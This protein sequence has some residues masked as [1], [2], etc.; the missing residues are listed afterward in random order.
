MAAGFVVSL[1]LAALYLHIATR[2][3]EA[4][5]QIVVIQKDANL[6]AQAVERERAEESSSFNDL[7]ATHVQVFRSP[8]VLQRAV[9]K[10]QL[11]R[12]PTFVAESEKSELFDP[13]M[14]ITKNLKV[15]KGGDAAEKDARVLRASFRGPSR[16]DCVTVLDAVVESYQSFLGETF[17]GTSSEA[18]RL[19][20]QAEKDLEGELRKA[21]EDYRNFREQSSLL[22]RSEQRTANPY[23]ER[24]KDIDTALIQ[25]KLRQSEVLSRL[26]VVRTAMQS[27]GEKRPTDLEQLA[28]IGQEEMS[29]IALMIATMRGDA[30]TS[31]TFQSKQPQRLVVAEAE[32]R[33]L[34]SLMLR[35]R[36]MLVDYGS[37]HP[38]IQKI[39]DQIETGREFLDKKSPP[40]LQRK[41]DVSPGELFSAYVTLLENDLAQLERREKRLLELSTQETAAGKKLVSAEIRDEILRANI[42][43]KR[44]MYDA[45][46]DRMKKISLIKDYS[47][48]LTPVISPV[49]AAKK[50]VSPL[51]SLVLA[52]GGFLGIFAGAA[53]GYVIDLS[54]RTFRTPEEVCRLLELPILGD[55]PTI[56]GAKRAGA[57]NGLR[58]ID[59]KA[60]AYHR[61]QSPEA[62]MIR[63]LRTAFS[64][65]SRSHGQK[66]IQVTSPMSGDGKTLLVANLAVSLAHAGKKVLIV[67]ADLRK[68]MIAKFFSIDSGV[69]LSSVISG[70]VDLPDAVQD[71]G[72]E[73]LFV[74]PSG[75]CPPNPSEFL[76]SREFEQL[77]AVVRNQY[78]Y[79]LIDSPPVLAAADSSEIASRVDGVLLTVRI[80]RNGSIA[81]GQ[82]RRRL[83][84]VAARL[85]GVVV[86][87]FRKNRNYVDKYYGGYCCY[88]D[89]NKPN[90][91]ERRRASRDEDKKNREHPRKEIQ[92]DTEQELPVGN[93]RDLAIHG[94]HESASAP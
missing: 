14:Y 50:A 11:D 81:A 43:R 77:L 27:D 15:M 32:Y 75:A 49:E 31:E 93:G 58:A 41:P 10:H 90:S 71:V 88:G 23:E 16:E 46:V 48:Y 7:L 39:R 91:H 52:I 33:D 79:V 37:D 5:V 59:F 80:R 82:A 84:A 17:Q 1:A 63:G 66:V 62:E 56:R 54:D 8:R 22:S 38:E 86:N 65:A 44:A 76:L 64:S 6:P 34:L 51:L 20:A 13:I 40:E 2:I 30:N 70:D 78:D 24:L 92:T 67:D 53:L 25:N 72:I 87:G 36:E 4:T 68:P 42:V 57:R 69:G 83:D 21:E 94:K 60:A 85:L 26:E 18:V 19:M 12:L 45:V 89:Y 3:Y 29:R 35:E 9:E 73:N 28:R 74:L 55:V 61:P 47:G